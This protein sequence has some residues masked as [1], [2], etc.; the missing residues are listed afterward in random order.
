MISV[1]EVES[2]LRALSTL[3]FTNILAAFQ[4]RGLNLSEDADA[5]S[6]LEQALADVG[7]PGM[8]EIEIGTDIIM[9]VVQLVLT[10]GTQDKPGAQLPDWAGGSNRRGQ[11]QE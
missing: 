11:E 9:T 10:Y 8:L 6:T 3:N 5:I 1:S 2:A 4:S 7:V